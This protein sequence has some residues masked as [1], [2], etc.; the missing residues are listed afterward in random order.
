MPKTR[1]ILLIVLAA[2]IIAGIYVGVRISGFEKYM[3][4]IK[5]EDVDISK[6][7][8]G[9]Y[10]GFSDSGVIIVKIQV[11]VKNHEITD[12]KL[13]QHFNGQGQD[14]E[15]ILGTIIEQQKNKVD[16]ITGA[17]LSSKV[18]M[19]AIQKALESAI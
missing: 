2:A 11:T 12:L 10:T 16:I 3:D 14:A 1:I 6:I 15:K 9:T 5:I 8:D 4:N 7:P 13:L 19:E 18:I 17:T